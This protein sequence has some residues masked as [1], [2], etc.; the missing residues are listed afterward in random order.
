MQDL[1]KHQSKQERTLVDYEREG[2]EI[3]DNYQAAGVFQ[4]D[5]MI[6]YSWHKIV[7][8]VESLQ[9]NWKVI[10]R[11]ISSTREID[12]QSTK[13]LY[14]SQISYF[15]HQ[16][17]HPTFFVSTDLLK[18]ATLYNDHLFDTPYSYPLIKYHLTVPKYARILEE[19]DSDSDAW[20]DQEGQ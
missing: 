12:I 13:N 7:S 6:H 1:I 20:V 4:P 3:S 8:L 10:L 2:E 16:L 15:W 19:G 14:L 9:T 18:F 17:T 5:E 11:Q